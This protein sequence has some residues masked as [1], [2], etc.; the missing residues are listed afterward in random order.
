MNWMRAGELIGCLLAKFTI[1][2]MYGAGFI[3]G[4][5][6]VAHYLFNGK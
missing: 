5:V 2:F 4:F 3:T 6:T 1:G